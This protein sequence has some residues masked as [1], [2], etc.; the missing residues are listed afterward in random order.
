M[1]PASL[2]E[3]TGYDWSVN[4]WT[5]SL[6]AGAATLLIGAAL[7]VLGYTNIVL[8]HRPSWSWK[9]RLTESFLGDR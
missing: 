1:F 5:A 4:R 2:G 8:A 6:I 9:D 7:E 3:S